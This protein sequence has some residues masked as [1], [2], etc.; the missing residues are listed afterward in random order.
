MLKVIL[1]ASVLIILTTM[2]HAVAMIIAIHWT[3]ALNQLRPGHPVLV[4][5]RPAV[6]SLT[7]LLMFL[8]STF[9]VWIWATAYRMLGAFR[10]LEPAMYFSMVSFTTL[11]YGDIVLGEEWRLLS[12]LQAA[13]GIIIFGWTTAIV[14]MVVQRLYTKDSLGSPRDPE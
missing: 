4:P 1:I 7:V 11:G 8:T 13:S 6:V 12:S 3:R 9:E 2:V 5:G 10:E 14:I